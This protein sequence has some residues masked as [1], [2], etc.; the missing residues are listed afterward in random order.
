MFETIT[1]SQLEVL[2]STDHP[3]LVDVRSASEFASGHIPGAMNIPMQEIESRRED[4]DRDKPVILICQ[5]GTRARVAAE[6]LQSSHARLCVLDG[7][8]QAWCNAGKAVVIVSAASRWSLERQVRLVAGMLV[9]IGAVLALLSSPKWIYLPMLVG[10]GLTFAG[11][12]D[13]C[14]MGI[15]LAR[16]P[17]NRSKN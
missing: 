10:A 7:G 5:A 15:L 4:F 9:F 13:I 2:C 3:Q 17:W 11:V 8:T 16:M 14:G 1:H 6:W 12:T